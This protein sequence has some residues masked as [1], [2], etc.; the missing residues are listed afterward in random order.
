MCRIRPDRS[1]HSADRRIAPVR[2]PIAAS[3]TSGRR[4]QPAGRPVPLDL[5]RPTTTSRVSHHEVRA[6]ALGRNARDASRSQG[7]PRGTD[8]R[9]CRWGCHLGDDV[10]G[11]SRN[12]TVLV[13]GNR[14]RIR[15][16]EQHCRLCAG[17]QRGRPGS[18]PRVHA[19]TVSPRCPVSAVAWP[20][21][22]GA[23]SRQPWV[24]GLPQRHPRGLG[25]EWQFV[26][27]NHAGGSSRCIGLERCARVPGE[28]S[29]VYWIGSAK[30]AETRARRV[31]QFVEMLARGE[32]I[33][34]QGPRPSG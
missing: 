2:Y 20:S 15:F 14:P 18:A 30:K 28:Y 3:A 8:R 6:S 16:L 17:P 4:L 34:P 24:P 29:I 19:S 25:R 33:H 7:G 26:R 23:T 1:D 21:T 32:T 11:S 9:L 10:R 22:N 13:S 27:R 5:R 12:D 31:E